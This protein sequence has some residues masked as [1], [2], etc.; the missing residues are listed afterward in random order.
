MNWSA[1]TAPFGRNFGRNISF[2]DASKD[3]IRV[4]T[5]ELKNF[6]SNDELFDGLS[7][8]WLRW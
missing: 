4:V 1:A 8:T 6:A 2:F 7:Q 5:L 3:K